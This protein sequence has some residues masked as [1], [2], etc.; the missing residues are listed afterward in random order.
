MGIFSRKKEEDNLALIYDIGSSSVAAAL[1]ETNKDGIPKI[2]FSLREPIVFEEKINAERFLF[3]TLKSLE[4]LNSKLAIKGIGK[5]SKICCT[6]SSPWYA[7]QTR[8][9]K[10]EKNTPFVFTS[11]LADDLIK[12]EISIFEEEN[13]NRFSDSPDKARMIEFKNMKVM[14]N[15][16]PTPDPF[17]KK[18]K[19][20]EMVIF[21]SMSGDTLLKKI[22]NSIFRHFHNNDIKFISFSF[23]SFTVARDMFIHKDN[24]ILV[25]IAGEVTDISMIKKD[26]LSDSISYPLGR[27]FIIREVANSLNCSLSEARSYLSLFKDGHAT[28]AVERKL[29]PI[30]TKLKNEWTTGF[31]QSLISISN[32]I[33]IPSTIFITVDKELTNFFSEMIKNEQFN[34]YSLT[35]SE[36]N[37]VFLDTPTLHGAVSFKDGIERDPFITIESIYINRFLC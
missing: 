25:D 20:V 22:E 35:E 10:F 8:T 15:G 1:L 31:Q 28:E 34:Q 9:I 18:A 12:K 7:S 4:T 27:N 23:A 19:K 2:I 32:D 30:I 11:K 13:I 6:L 21:V 36:F 14:L 29:N 37:I 3:L 26:I 17:N 33:S 24:F 5:P 16:Y